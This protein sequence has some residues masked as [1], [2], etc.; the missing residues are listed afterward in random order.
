MKA[1]ATGLLLAAVIAALPAASMGADAKHCIS[2]DTIRGNHCNDPT[3]MTVKVTNRCDRTVYVK[4]CLEM[5]NGK[6]DCGS[7]SRLRVGET[8]YGFWT[9]KA[10]GR[11]RWDACTGGH[12]ECG[13]WQ[14]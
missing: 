4:V 12:E 2:L 5:P 13:R 1:A 9:C 14:P 7:D 10:T 3:S 11:Y 8:N 6:H